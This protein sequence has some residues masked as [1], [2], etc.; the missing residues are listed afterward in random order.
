MNPRSVSRC[1]RSA[2]VLLATLWAVAAHAQ[3]ITA[4]D[5]PDGDGVSGLATA[6]PPLEDG[7][8]GL[9]VISKDLDHCY[10][11]LYR[12]TQMSA[13]PWDL[14]NRTVAAMLARSG[15]GTRILLLAYNNQFQPPVVYLQEDGYAVYVHLQ[16]AGYL[17]TGYPMEALPGLDDGFLRQFD[18]IVDW[19]TGAFGS[20]RLPTSGV[21]VLTI[22]HGVATALGLG[23][24]SGDHRIVWSV[25]ISESIGPTAGLVP[26][27]IDFDDWMWTYAL[28][29]A[30]DALTL[31]RYRCPTVS[32][33]EINSGALKAM[34]R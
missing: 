9:V 8:S 2:V 7:S 4:V 24:F 27:D 18:L 17:V 33:E 29:P 15:G 19:S 5:D 1:S 34:F 13:E 22:N 28:G 21:P 11:G 26:G 31:V 30:R 14:F 12:A 25:C 10:F 6:S 20:G 16:L 3:A 32:T 23:T